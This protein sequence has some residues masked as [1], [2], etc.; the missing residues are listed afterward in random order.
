MATKGQWVPK[1]RLDNR[2][3]QESLAVDPKGRPGATDKTDTMGKPVSRGRWVL[4]ETTVLLARRVHPDRMAATVQ[5]G[6]KAQQDMMAKM[7]TTAK[8]AKMGMMDQSALRALA[9]PLPLE[10]MALSLSTAATPSK[11]SLQNAASRSAFAPGTSSKPR[12]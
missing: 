3:Q 9:A 10:L 8:M 12:R 6:L 4:K 1:V 2:G 11:L 5:Q 7:G